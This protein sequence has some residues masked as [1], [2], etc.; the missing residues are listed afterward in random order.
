MMTD[1][2]A[3]FLA[4]TTL[5]CCMR[6]LRRDG[7]T[8]TQQLLRRPGRRAW[9]SE[10]LYAYAREAYRAAPVHGRTAEEAA[11][12]WTEE[13]FSPT[14][15]VPVFSWRPLDKMLGA[16]TRQEQEESFRRSLDGFRARLE[17]RGRA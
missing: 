3:L 2:T 14:P 1:G 12:L 11:R 13:L 4:E 7:V 17:K 15:G 5:G 8:T 10:A 9:L 6:M 16:L